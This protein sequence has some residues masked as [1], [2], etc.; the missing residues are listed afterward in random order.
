MRERA[1]SVGVAAGRQEQCRWRPIPGEMPLFD[2]LGRM[3]VR[4][5]YNDEKVSDDA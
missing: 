4:I 5:E 3:P 1:E 2:R